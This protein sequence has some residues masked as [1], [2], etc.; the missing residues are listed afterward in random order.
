MQKSLPQSSQVGMTDCSHD[1][2][3][4][5]V[6]YDK[7]MPAINKL[8]FAIS[9]YLHIATYLLAAII[10]MLLFLVLSFDLAIV[11]VSLMI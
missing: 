7:N 10:K 4:R 9:T 1:R 3:W 11:I 5:N 8:E 6:L 2:W